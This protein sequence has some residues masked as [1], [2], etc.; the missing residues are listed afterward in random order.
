M[1]KAREGIKSSV[2]PPARCLKHLNGATVYGVQ[3]E[4]YQITGQKTKIRKRQTN[5]DKGERI[6]FKRN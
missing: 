3:N 4:W 2:Q 5:Y 6:D 1:I